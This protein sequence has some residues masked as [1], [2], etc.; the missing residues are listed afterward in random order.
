MS[1][2]KIIIGGHSQ[3]PNTLPNIPNAELQFCKVG[4][5]KLA[6]FW[7]HPAFLSMRENKHDLA[8]LFLGGND[9]YDGCN[10]KQIAT[11]IVHIADY[12]STNNTDTV[13]T[14]L[15]P[16]NYSPNNR[17]GLNPE[18]YTSVARAVNR[19]LA[20][21]LKRRSIRTINL[22]ARPFQHGHTRD[23]VHFNSVSKA[24]VISKFTKC[25]EHHMSA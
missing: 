13:I 24:H 1:D 8:I 15:E 7:H 22:G 5:A 6:D 4:G 19:H 9:V 18:T 3:I 23:G 17:F 20:K 10:P 2:Y 12:L 21:A 25:I 14:L 16:R 11:G